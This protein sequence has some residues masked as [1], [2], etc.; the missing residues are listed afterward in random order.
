MFK[1]GDIKTVSSE[2]CLIKQPKNASITIAA[3]HGASSGR[4]DQ[5][6]C[7]RSCLSLRS[8]TRIPLQVMAAT[9]PRMFA[10]H[11]S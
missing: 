11:S 8:L 1:T 2:T 6:E 4:T 5:D 9:A 7:R 10:D 3:S